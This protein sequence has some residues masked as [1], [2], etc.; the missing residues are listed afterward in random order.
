MKVRILEQKEEKMWDE[1]VK[2]HPQ[3]NIHQASTW[4]HF[5][6]TIPTRGKFWII[7]IE[8]NDKII[9]GTLLIR[10]SLPKEYTWLYSPRGPLLDYSN[11]D[12]SVINK[13]IELIVREVTKIGKSQNSVFYRIDPLLIKDKDSQF[14]PE[15]FKETSHGFQPEHTLIINLEQ[16]EEDIQKDMK[17]KGRYNIRVAEKKGVEIHKSDPKDKDQFAKDILD[18]YKILQETT[19]RDGFHGH[20]LDFYKN[21][22]EML[23][24]NNIGA[25]YLA[26][27]QGKTIAGLIATFFKETAIYYYGVSS[28]ENRNVMAPYLLQWKV[29]QDAKQQGFK[30]Y[31]FFGISPPNSPNHPWAGVRRFKKK[32][33]GQEVS[34]YPAMDYSLKPVVHKLYKFYK[35]AKK[36]LK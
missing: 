14:K 11:S 1:F 30:K 26:K 21:M 9:A 20:Q 18:Y 35:E 31:D 12:Q 2:K 13:Q 25:M 32:F 29:I 10:S 4:G 24:E 8:E 34:Y 5:Q 23:S 15:K 7:A 27:Y 22:V 28:N 16:T 6:K 36:K 3:G 17:Q 19:R 33:G